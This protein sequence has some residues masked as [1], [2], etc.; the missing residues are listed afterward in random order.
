MIPRF[1][2]HSFFFQ[3]SNQILVHMDRYKASIIN[4]G[5]CFW[6]WHFCLQVG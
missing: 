6:N 3:L 5:N 1:N 2:Y 4:M